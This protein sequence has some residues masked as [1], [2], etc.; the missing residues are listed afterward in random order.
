MA[1]ETR[2]PC[3]GLNAFLPHTHSD[4]RAGHNK[5]STLRAYCSSAGYMTVISPVQIRRLAP[6]LLKYAPGLVPSRPSATAARA[7]IGPIR[8]PVPL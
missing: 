6:Q 3:N 1:A 2:Q 5:R 4:G 7:A 8:L